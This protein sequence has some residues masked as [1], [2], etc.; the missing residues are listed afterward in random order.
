MKRKILTNILFCFILMLFTGVEVH[1]Q[2]KIDDQLIEKLSKSKNSTEFV[3]AIIVLSDHYNIRSL[4]RRLTDQKVTPH[5]R[6]VTVISELQTHADHTQQSL[7]K[8]LEE[9]ST[10]GKVRQIHPFWISNDIYIE[11][12]PKVILDL[13][14]RPD[15]RYI[16]PNAEVETVKHE[17]TK[18]AP[19]HLP[20]EA[21]PGLKIINAHKMWEL[22]YTGEGVVVASIDGGVE[23]THP[24]LS[25]NWRGNDV[26]WWQAWY[27]PSY[28][29]TFPTDTGGPY[30]GHGTLTMGVMAGLDAAVQDTIGVAF[31][32]KW[33]AS[34]INW[35]SQN[36]NMWCMEWMMNPDSN[37]V[38]TD[39]IPDVVI[40]EN[41]TGATY[42]FDLLLPCIL[43]LEAAGVAMIFCAGNTGPEPGWVAN[44][45]ELRETDLIPFSVGAIDG[46]VPGLP[47]A[48]FSSR[49]P[50][51]CP[52]G[53]GDYIK[54]EVCAPGVSIRSSDT[55]A[56]YYYASGT[57]F[58]VPHVAGAIAL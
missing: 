9:Q 14:G 55:S 22:G 47:I 40:Y 10:E 31:G 43:A 38:T 23:G 52:H 24:A 34:R 48:P 41:V 3:E 36:Q 16:L 57:S 44:P 33:I 49:G 1:S 54:P 5:H 8:Y 11:A 56:S 46:N 58:A 21:E 39:D 12:L 4:D 20:G 27:D 13:A 18:P 7:L 29:T 50:T 45:A 51:T 17:R 15:V 2:S 53:T 35:S 6:A 30:D 25:N 42:C 28:N 19:D 26:P 32:S 37:D